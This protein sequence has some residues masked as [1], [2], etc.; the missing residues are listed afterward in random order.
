MGKHR[1]GVDVFPT[2]LSPFF[3]LMQS[4]SVILVV[5]VEALAESS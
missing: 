3:M 1:A 4:L 2:M 5:Q